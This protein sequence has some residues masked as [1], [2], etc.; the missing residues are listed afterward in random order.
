MGRSLV[1]HIEGAEETGM[2]ITLT[3]RWFGLE[4]IQ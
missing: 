3:R 4:F 2:L 1:Q